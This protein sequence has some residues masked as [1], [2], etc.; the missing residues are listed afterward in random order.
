ML[1]YR[2]KNYSPKNPYIAKKALAAM[3]RMQEQAERNGLSEMTLE[4]INAEIY[5]ARR[6]REAREAREAQ[7]VQ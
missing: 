7:E 4:E 1:N 5:A 3:K 6:E 2:R